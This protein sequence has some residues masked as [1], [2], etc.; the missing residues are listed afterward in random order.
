MT[1]KANAIRSLKTLESL[2]W[3]QNITSQETWILR[4]A[5]VT[6]ANLTQT[7]VFNT[8]TLGTWTVANSN[9]LLCHGCPSEREQTDHCW[10]NFCEILYRG[11]RVL[12]FAEK[13]EVWLK[14][15]K[16]QQTVGSSTVSC[17]SSFAVCCCCNRVFY[18]SLQ[19]S[20]VNSQ[21]Q[22][23]SAHT[24]VWA[25]HLVMIMPAT[26][27]Y[28][29]IQQYILAC[30]HVEAGVKEG[31][32]TKAF[33]CVFLDYFLEMQF[34]TWF[35]RIHFGTLH[36]SSMWTELHHLCTCYIKCSTH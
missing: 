32:I 17:G 22:A 27:S 36:L 5:A 18:S 35:S 21:Y 25:E 16:S 14:I 24:A 29:D 3:W 13:T 9:C 10:T 12:Q 33:I 11:E 34:F 1:I 2:T 8:A 6:T 20:G 31:A 15:D 26:K 28:P 4:N 7:Q 23:R 19:F 30:V